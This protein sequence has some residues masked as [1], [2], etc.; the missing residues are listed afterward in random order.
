MSSATTARRAL[1]PFYVACAAAIL[2]PLAGC[3][4][5]APP[6]GTAATAPAG[7]VATASVVTPTP[8]TVEQRPHEVVAPH[9]HVRVDEYYWLR[10]RDNPQVIEYLEAEN[11]YTDAVMAGTEELQEQVFQEIRGRIQETDMSVPVRRGD[12]WYYTRYEEGQDHPIHARKRG[13]LDAPEE[14]LLDANERAEGKR[15]YRVS[16]SVSSGDDILAFAE[17]TLGRNIVTVRFKDLGTGRLLDDVIENVTW[18]LSWAED[19]RTIFFARQDPTTLRSYQ[20]YRHRLGDD[21]AAAELVY[22]ETDETFRSYVFKT[23]SREY[24]I[25]GSS[26]T[27]SNEYRVLRADRPDGEFR[28]FI[29][30]ERGHEHSID[31]FGDH[32]YIVTNDDAKNFRLM[33]TPVDRTA[34]GDWEEVIPHRADVFLNG[35]EPFR[36]RMVLFERQD[37]MTQLRVR[38]WNGEDD[39]Y[40]RFDEEAYVVRPSANPELDTDIL[41]L[42]YQSMTT[43][44]S[45]YDYD[46]TSRELTLLKRDEVLGGYDPAEY[47]TERVFATA[48]DGTRVPVSLV[49]RRDLRQGGHPAAA[50]LRLRLL[51]LVDGSGLLVHPAEPAGPRIHLRHRPHPRWSGD[52]AGTG[53]SRASCYRSGTRSTTSSTP[54]STWWRPATPRPTGSTPRVAAPAACSWAPSSICGPTC[55]TAPSPPSRSWTW[56]PP[57]WTRPSPSPRSSGTS[58][59]TRATRSTTTTCW[60]TRPTTTWRKRSIPTSWSRPAC[61]TPRSSTGRRPSGWLASASTTRATTSSC[62]RPTWT[63]ATAAPPAGTSAGGRSRSSTP[64]SWT[65]PA[66]RTWSRWAHPPR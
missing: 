3:A 37:G 54:P 36:D 48:R 20:I 12:Y 61:T 5:A 53:T 41:R 1:R 65:W 30:R 27:L 24:M 21:P 50:A 56:S 10:E 34:R 60:A 44:G 8:P 19:N 31:H 58:G 52:S 32:F 62:S 23:K 51:R 11:A 16:T 40:I 33:R 45:V 38:G 66:W 15:F 13:S 29:P 46:M 14:V 35:F 2:V 22:E 39:H 49:Y 64:S 42:S 17:D 59:A 47:R 25:I 7:Q 28:L 9:G 6:Q 18:N 63:P 57:C 26:H 43:P 55:S 4:G